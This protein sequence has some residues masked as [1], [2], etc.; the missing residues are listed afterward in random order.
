MVRHKAHNNEHRRE[1]RQAG[2]LDAGTFREHVGEAGEHLREVGHLA[3]DAAQAGMRRLRSTAKA[4]LDQGW[5]KV[6]G[7]EESV[8][9]RVRQYPIRSVLV[10]AGVGFLCSLLLRRL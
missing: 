1:S 10:A 2:T 5:D 8:E 6:K 4:T 3:K 9:G 7:L